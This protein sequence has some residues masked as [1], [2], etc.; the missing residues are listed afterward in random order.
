MVGLCFGAFWGLLVVFLPAKDTANFHGLRF[1]FLFGGGLL[2]LFGFQKIDFPGSGAL[3]VLVMAF[4]AGVGWR[5]QGWTDEDN[6]VAQTLAKM[7][8]IF[9][10][11]LFG[12]I[13][14]EIQVS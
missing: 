13:G 10:P 11:I 9:Q 3:A 5:K 14:T 1:L 4:V 7:W 8:V 12:L 2:A 6:T